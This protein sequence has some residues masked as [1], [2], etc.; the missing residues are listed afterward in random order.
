MITLETLAKLAYVLDCNIGELVQ[1][2]YTITKEE[3]EVS[4][5]KAEIFLLPVFKN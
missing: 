1:F 3:W 2:E 5:E 4:V